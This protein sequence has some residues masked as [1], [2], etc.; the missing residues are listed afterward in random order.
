[1]VGVSPSG[2][3]RGLPVRALGGGL[4]AT[5]PNAEKL[6][7]PVSSDTTTSTV[8]SPDAH[9][10]V[11]DPSRV[12]SSPANGMTRGNTA[13][14]GQPGFSPGNVIKE[15]PAAVLDVSTSPYDAN[16]GSNAPSCVSTP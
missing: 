9:E 11:N 3:E 5:K 8:V 10:I 13:S 1:M 2:V 16:A 14:V 6:M 15:V 7:F 12:L 4:Y